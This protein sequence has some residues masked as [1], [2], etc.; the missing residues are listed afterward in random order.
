MDGMVK[1]NTILT[2]ILIFFIVIVGIM[3]QGDGANDSFLKNNLQASSSLPNS[4]LMAISYCS[5]N[6]ILLIPVLIPLSMILKNKEIFKISVIS[7]FILIILSLIIFSIIYTIN[8]DITT[9]EIPVLYA[10]NNFGA[11]LKTIY[12]FVFLTAVFATAISI[13]IWLFI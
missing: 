12:N 2:P 8:T 13:R 5:Y 6:S 4:I 7:V 3:S 11:F 1:A 9:L 10:L